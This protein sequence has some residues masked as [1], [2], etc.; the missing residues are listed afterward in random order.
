M[1]TGVAVGCWVE[2]FWGKG[3]KQPPWEESDKNRTKINDVFLYY[4]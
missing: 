1:D 3:S 4:K 2:K